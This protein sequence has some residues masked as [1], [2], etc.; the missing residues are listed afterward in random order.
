MTTAPQPLP[1][2]L[3]T[4]WEP[5]APL[6]DTLLRQSVFGLAATNVDVARAMGGRVLDEDGILAADLGVPNAIFNTAVV[7]HPP[8]PAAW[9]AVAGT[10]E[11][12]FAGGTSGRVFLFSPWPTPDLRARGWELEGHPP[13]LV[14]PAGLALP[15]AP[16][17]LDIRQVTD[18]DT[19]TDCKRVLVDG[20]PFDEHQPFDPKAWLDAR[21]L[22]L[23][24]HEL[25][26]GYREGRP[27]TAGWLV[28]HE[29]LGVLVMGATLPEARRRGYWTGML[30][31]RLER[32]GD[33]VTASLFSDDSRP[34]AERYGF[35]PL[36]RFTAW[37]RDR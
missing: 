32:V 23:P 18:Q 25:Y 5:D 10:V 4:G 8:D 7:T 26:L 1:G 34:G 29:G 17:D 12:F 15:D 30:R 35:L 36:L 33:A 31:R 21:V 11:A 13:L 20:F 9:E 28:R 6:D 16:S 37:H 2:H 3:T 27:V 24:G 19:L 22:G 14:R